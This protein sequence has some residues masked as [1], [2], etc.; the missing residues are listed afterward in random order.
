MNINDID[1]Y[2]IPSTKVQK[3]YRKYDY[4]N[5]T[6][7]KI[8]K[9]DILYKKYISTKSIKHIS[10]NAI[11]THLREISNTLFIHNISI[12]NILYKSDYATHFCIDT[13]QNKLENLCFY[14]NWFCDINSEK[15]TIDITNSIYGTY[16]VKYEFHKELI[17]YPFTIYTVLYDTVH[18]VLIDKTTGVEDLQY[19]KIRIPV[20]SNK[21][22]EW[23]EYNPDYCLHYFL[24]LFY[25]YSPY[26][27]E[28]NDYIISYFTRNFTKIYMKKENNIEY[29]KKFIIENVIHGSVLYHDIYVYNKSE[30]IIDF[31][32]VMREYIDIE[33]IQKI[34]KIFTDN[35]IYGSIVKNNK[36]F[37]SY[38]VQDFN[39]KYNNAIMQKIP[40]MNETYKDA[41]DKIYTITDNIYI[42]GGTIRDLL[43]DIE[44]TD[45][46][47]TFDSTLEQV[48][49]LCSL[50]K[51]PCVEILPKYKKVT[52]GKDRGITLEGTYCND[53][54][55]VKMEQIDF[56]IN[57][58]VYDVKNNTLIDITGVGIK[59]LLQKKIRIPVPPSKYKIWASDWK[60]PLL[61]FKMMYKGFVPY[62]EQTIQFVVSYIEENFEKVY[63][64]KNEEGNPKIQHY[65]IKV[66]T[67]GEIIN[68]TI[69]LGSTKKRLTGYL[70][71]MSKHINTKTM[72]KI[73]HLVDNI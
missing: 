5:Y 64:K 22:K 9:F 52:F 45:I 36:P 3:I 6:F 4:K 31:I 32:T 23:I 57:K 42:Y 61:F 71:I 20:P 10:Y 8:Q 16:K 55:D 51:W 67:H 37:L 39:T 56:T 35:T 40:D 11:L 19:K 46:D 48:E 13:T 58:I 54:F 53:V 63:M 17:K 18:K 21:Y 38:I 69:I 25:G 33:Y 14:K 73:I 66:L 27:Q 26:N 24:L 50:T 44:P 65:L 29:I 60:K 15:K 1:R 41:F 68:N 7:Y 28:T 47:I 43:L 49:T 62:D 2:R 30:Y 59:D 12:H 72:K 70:S 34:I